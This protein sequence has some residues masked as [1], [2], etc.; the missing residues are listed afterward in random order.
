[1]PIENHTDRIPRLPHWRYVL[2]R[3]PD[4]HEY[5]EAMAALARFL[6][7]EDITVGLD[8]LDE[9]GKDI[10][11]ATEIFKTPPFRSVMENFLLENCNHRIIIDAFW[12]KFKENVSNEVILYYKKYFFDL[13]IVN[14]YDIARYYEKTGRRL[15]K[16]PPVPGSMRE[17]YAA[18][19]QGEEVRL[20]PDDIAMHM[21]YHAFFRAK[22]LSELGWQ[23]DDKSL[24]YLRAANDM[25]KT[26]RDT[27]AATDLPDQFN[28]EVEYPDSTA[29]DA[30]K[31]EGYDIDEE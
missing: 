25:L 30:D 7:E 27:D 23:G 29:I 18:F 8:K 15:P 21:F 28:F 9:N 26:M 4:H 6:K 17:A 16:A 1:M 5:D 3:G 12:H 2:W 31:L 19:K 20:N 10:Q 13:D 14:T 11:K 24:K 22:E